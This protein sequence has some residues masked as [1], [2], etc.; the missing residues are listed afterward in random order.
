MHVLSYVKSS[1]ENDSVS[2]SEKLK[3]REKKHTNTHTQQTLLG[4]THTENTV[5][6]RIGKFK[7]LKMKIRMEKQQEKNEMKEKQ[8][9]IMSHSVRDSDLNCKPFILFVFY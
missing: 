8:Q 2:T 5:G 1:S 9:N 4:Q 6:I 7:S 3:N